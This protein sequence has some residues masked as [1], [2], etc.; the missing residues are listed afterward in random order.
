MKLQTL[1]IIKEREIE[2]GGIGGE[3]GELNLQFPI[4]KSQF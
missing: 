1:S 4:L 3:S 2:F